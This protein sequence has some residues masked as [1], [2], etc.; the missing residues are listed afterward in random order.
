MRPCLHSCAVGWRLAGREAAAGP[1]ALSAARFPK[2]KAGVKTLAGLLLPRLV[3]V[4]TPVGAHSCLPL[5]PLPPAQ[6]KGCEAWNA[7]CV[8]GTKVEQCLSN[9]PAVGVPTTY[10]TK[11]DIDVRGCCCCNCW[12]CSLAS[13]RTSSDASVRAACKQ[14]LLEEQRGHA[15]QAPRLPPKCRRPLSKRRA[16][17]PRSTRRAC[18][19]PTPWTAA[20]S[21]PPWAAPTSGRA[22]RCSTSTAASACVSWVVAVLQGRLRRRFRPAVPLADMPLLPGLAD[23][24]GAQAH[25]SIRAGSMQPTV[26]A[27][28]SMH[29]A[30][31]TTCTLGCLILQPCQT[32]RR[33]TTGAS[34]APTRTQRAP[35]PCSAQAT[36]PTVRTG[37]CWAVLAAV[38]EGCG[39]RSASVAAPLLDCPAAQAK[40]SHA[41][42]RSH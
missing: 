8:S 20:R 13:Q 16:C 28:L 11:A 21:A 29:C 5:P 25:A 18:A 3:D 34:S 35:S 24:L 22:P 39:C 15:I 6:M 2:L 23:R 19:P 9:P 36:P 33:A 37:G 32:W 42:R 10:S 1:R 40:C 41:G 12:L 17:L 30:S 26:P 38:D 7:L 31:L 4:P 27:L 14:R